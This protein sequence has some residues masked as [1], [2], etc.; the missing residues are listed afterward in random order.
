MLKLNNRK[1]LMPSH[2]NTALYGAI[3]LLI[4]QNEKEVLRRWKMKGIHTLH[5]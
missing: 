2:L 1:V 4:T 5:V 3:H